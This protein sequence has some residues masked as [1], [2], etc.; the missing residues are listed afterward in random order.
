MNAGEQVTLPVVRGFLESVERFGVP[1]HAMQPSFGMAEA[2]TCMTFCNDFSVEGG[3][4]FFTKAS[5]GGVLDP[6]SSEDP[7]T[8]NFIDLGPPVPGIEIRIT[9]AENEVVCERKIGRFQIRGPVITPG[10]L[11]NHKANAEAFVG[12]EWFNSGDLGFIHEGRLFLTGR[13]KE[14]IIIRSANFYCYEIEDIVNAMDEVIPTFQA[15]CPINYPDT[16]TE[17]LAILYTPKPEREGHHYELIP[18]IRKEVTERLGVTPSYIIPLTEKTFPKTTSGKIQRS[19]LSKALI[20]GDFDAELRNID[21]YLSNENTMPDWFSNRTWAL[22]KV[23]IQRDSLTGT[24]VIWMDESGLGEAWLEN[25]SDEVNVVRIYTQQVPRRRMEPSYVM[26]AMDAAALGSVF[27]E[28]VKDAP[29]YLVN[30][31]SYGRRG[32][33]LFTADQ[34]EDQY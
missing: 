7:H 30:L 17:G 28:H 31:R 32:V 9:D 26:D 14:M 3:A 34:L 6:A 5:L 4:K 13:E 21:L 16:G 25:I 18:K 23:D 8:I 27:E 19:K 2:C 20:G 12:D 1:Q 33:E 22:R 10:Y 24:V 29:L 15:A 11:H